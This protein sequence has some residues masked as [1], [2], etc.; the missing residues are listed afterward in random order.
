MTEFEMGKDEEMDDLRSGR[1]PLKAAHRPDWK[2]KL[3]KKCLERVRANRARLLW[4]MRRNSSTAED[5]KEIMDSEFRTI[6]SDE[7]KKIKWSSPNNPLAFPTDDVDDTLWEYDGPN[8]AHGFTE[9]KFGLFSEELLIEMDKVFHEELKAEA[10]QRELEVL[11]RVYEEEDTYLAQ[12]V[13]EQMKL[14]NEK[15][16]GKD[17][18][19]C[20]ICKRGELK[21]NNLLISCTCCKLLLDI[22]SDKV[23]LEFLGIRLA[24]AHTEHL[25]R[26]C[27]ATPKFCLDAKFNITALYMYCHSCDTFEIVL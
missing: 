23:N 5:Q 2:G 11:E 26:G 18:F 14:T 6:V 24:E 8:Q 9:S 15:A 13:Y 27:H 22:Q 12:A 10:I 3:R 20:P 7:M 16:E 25:D 21:Q 19:W 4:K 1:S 17:P